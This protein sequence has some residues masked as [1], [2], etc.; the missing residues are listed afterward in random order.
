MPMPRPSPADRRAFV[1]RNTRI[2]PVP[3][4]PG[5]RLHLADDVAVAYHLAAAELGETDPGLP[6]WAFAGPAVSASPATSASIPTRWS[7]VASSTSPRNPDS[8][9]TRCCT[10]EPGRSGRS[11]SIR[12]RRPRS[13]ST[14]GSMGSASGSPAATR[15]LDPRR[16]AT[17]SLPAMSATSRPWAVAMTDWLTIAAAHG[18]RGCSLASRPEYLPPGLERVATHQVTTTRELEDR[19]LKQTS[20]F[21]IPAASPEV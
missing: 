1:R 14:P 3:D 18:T 2:Q 6:F 12:F 8:C 21:T 19:T 13:P 10:R 16:H 17:C 5:V 7:A 4:A 20:V 15:S 11:I 9:A